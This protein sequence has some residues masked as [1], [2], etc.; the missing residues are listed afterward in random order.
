MTL[1]TLPDRPQGHDRATEQAV[2]GA[3]LLSR[4]AIEDAQ[5][6]IHPSDFAHLPHELLYQAL[7]DHHADGTPTDAISISNT[8]ARRT[9][10]QATQLAALGGLPYIHDLIHGAALP[11]NVPHLAGIIR[12]AAVARRLTDAANRIAQLATTGKDPRTLLEEAHATLDRIEARTAPSA[13]I[14]TRFP[15]LDLAELL[16]PT[17]PPREFVLEGLIPAG[18]SVSLTAA[19]GTGKS[20]FSLGLAIAIARGRKT[21]ANLGIP[22]RRRV[23]YIDM[24]NT[25]DDLAERFEG[26]GI[27]QADT[28]P[29]LVYLSLPSLA[30]LDTR[31]GGTQLEAIIDA[32]QLTRHDVVVLDSFQR[33]TSGPENDSDTL[34]AYYLHTGMV[35]KRLGLTVLRL[36]NTGKDVTRGSRGTSG[37]RDDVDIELIMYKDA[38]DEERYRIEVGKSRLSDI[39]GMRITRTTGAGGEIQWSTTE[40]PFRAAVNAAHD[41]LDELGVP[42]DA[43]VRASRDAIR[44]TG[45]RFTERAIRVAVKERKGRART[46]EQAVALPRDTRDESVTEAVSHARDANERHT[47][48][49][50]PDVTRKTPSEIQ[51]LYVTGPAVTPRHSRVTRETPPKGR[52]TSRATHEC[53][54]CGEPMVDI[55]DGSTTH[56][57]CE[58]GQP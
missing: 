12:D 3:M 55:G 38:E 19:A 36:D 51:S 30:P 9:I 10:G 49:H 28:I 34:R 14:L 2:L 46:T 54:A 21:F 58:G 13:N 39:T 23:L 24:E 48:S 40:D 22:T 42:F 33:V 57:A 17:K 6:I 43:S 8:L 25:T 50:R 4:S 31:D 1:T 44:A 37:K 16:N 26:F 32:Y 7:V 53:E 56:P 41:T 35:L 15:A 5:V 11:G 20:L 45:R 29:E 52:H 47:A 27:T 18:A